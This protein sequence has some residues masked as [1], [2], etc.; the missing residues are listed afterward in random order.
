MYARF[1]VVLLLITGLSLSAQS[2]P[3]R[4]DGS[5]TM[6]LLGQ[7]CASIYKRET[8]AE[9]LVRGSSVP[10]ALKELSEGKVDI[11]QNDGSASG[12]KTS[13]PIA[14]HSLVV[15]VNKVNAVRDLTLDQLRGIY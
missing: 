14:V 3:I 8:N 13:I 1:T 5:D 15:Y 4:M 9:I 6:I 11:V 12:T 7:R 10:L 2:K